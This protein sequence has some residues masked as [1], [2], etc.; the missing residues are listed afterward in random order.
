[1]QAINAYPRAGLLD[2]VTQTLTELTLA[3]GNPNHYLIP[4]KSHDKLFVAS[5]SFQSILTGNASWS[6]YSTFDDRFSETAD[7]SYKPGE[8]DVIYYRGRRSSYDFSVID[9]ANSQILTRINVRPD[10]K[11]INATTDGKYI[12]VTSGGGI[13]FLKTEMIYKSI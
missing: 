3:S 12:I 4:S 9:Y 2:C 8:Q 1:M 7:F 5:F 11:N 13:Y 6:N 10:F